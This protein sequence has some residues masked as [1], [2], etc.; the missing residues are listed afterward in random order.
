LKNHIL[1]NTIHPLRHINL[2]PVRLAGGWSLVLI[3][4][5]RKVLLAGC[6][7]VLRGKYCWLVA[8]KPNEQAI[9]SYWQISHISSV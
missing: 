6:C 4:S 1:I 3:C 2:Q 5:E 8:D 9:N 7:F